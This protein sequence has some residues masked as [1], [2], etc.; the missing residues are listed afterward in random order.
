M[1]QELDANKLSSVRLGADLLLTGINKT[2]FFAT[3]DD[4]LVS[5]DEWYPV[6]D[7]A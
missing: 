5:G 2:F 7:V 6:R 1:L 3:A 4:E